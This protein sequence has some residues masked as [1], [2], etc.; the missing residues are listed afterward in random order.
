MKSDNKPSSSIAK[1]I[2]ER[3]GRFRAL[4]TASSDMIYCMSPDWST[5]IELE[6]RGFLP[7]SREPIG[8][9]MQKYIPPEEHEKVKQAIQEAVR[10]KKIFQLEHRVRLANGGVGWTSS[11]AVPVL[12]TEGEIIEWFGAAGD[13]TERREVEEELRRAKEQSE[14]QRRLYE[15]IA[16]GTPDLIYVFD[17]NYCFTYANKA[18]LTM[19]GKTWDEAIGKRLIENG[20]E[21]WHADMHEREIDQVR[22]TKTGIRGEVSF[23]HATLGRRIYDYIFTPVLDE[24]GEVEA[25]AGTTRDITDIRNAEMAMSESEARFRT[26][27]E[28]ADVMIALIDESGNGTYFNNRWTILTGRSIEALMQKGWA[29]LIL[30][31]DK[32]RLG[33]L[34]PAV[35]EKREHWK[36]ECRLA[37]QHGGYQ[38]VLMS[39]VPRL[40]SDGSFAGYICSAIDI[41]EIKE[42]EQRK[43]D[44]ISMVSHELKTPLTSAI[45]YVQ[46]IQS[47]MLKNEDISFEHLLS[48]AGRQLKKMTGLINSFLDVSRLE[49]GK[50]YMD[51]QPFDLSDLL[52]ELETE[53]RTLV[54]QHHLIFK[55]VDGASVNAD[56]EKIG[57]VIQNLISNAVK[58]A[59]QGSA[60][61]ISCSKKG[62]Q[63][64]VSVADEGP[65]VSPEDM[66]RIFERFYRVKNERLRSVSGFGIGLYLCR[67]IIKAHDG[68]I[69]VNSI[70]GQGSNFYFTLQQAVG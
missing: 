27:A 55:T 31:E 50:L 5:M 6:G 64:M 21:Q 19:W 48:R 22:A 57:Q 14:Q 9:W 52:R 20:Y 70:P 18:L 28:S 41:T 39:G 12:N 29:D 38:W 40:R 17:L 49:S 32:E 66:S 56:R 1:N 10:E 15:T 44:F 2:T 61:T 51:K 45:A 23:P 37:D 63:A 62:D 33:N 16:S 35:L 36:Y 67:E 65:G 11:R 3:E 24:W 43:N 69:G 8:D 25:V 60:I 46:L 54:E 34:V 7:D 30:P 58:Y 4:I 53:N 26:M 47:E 13:I 42:N 59:P 68:A